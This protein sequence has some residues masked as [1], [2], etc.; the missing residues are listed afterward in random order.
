MNSALAFLVV[1]DDDIIRRALVRALSTYGHVEGVGSC[2]EAHEVLRDRKF[3]SLV[4][5][6]GLPD[7][8]GL[9]LVTRARQ[10][11]PSIWVLVLTGNIEHAVVSRAHELGVRFLLKPFAPGHLSIHVEETRARRTAGDRRVSIAVDRWTRGHQLTAAETELLM[12]GARGVPREEFAIMRGVKP[13][14]IRKQIQALLHKT[15]DDTFEA[16]VNSLLR[17]AI[18]DPG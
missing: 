17:E 3:D 14:T 2:S 12:L 9:D 1:E 10:L 7:G 6:V 18:A 5:D 15:G 13:D 11:W 4:V 8:S 16:A